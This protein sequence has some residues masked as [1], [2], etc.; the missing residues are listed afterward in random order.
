MCLFQVLFHFVRPGKLLLA[1]HAGEHFASGALVVQ[2]CVPL[3]AVLVL[4]VLADLD[5]FALDAS[6]RSVWS[7]GGVAEEVQAPD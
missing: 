6:V 5:A 7:Q 4:E 2:E 1:D 3:E